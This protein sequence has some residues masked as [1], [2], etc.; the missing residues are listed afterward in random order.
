LNALNTE[1]GIS[2][3]AANSPRMRTGA[4]PDAT[5]IIGTINNCAG[6]ITPWGT[7]IT[8]EENINYYFS[9]TLPVGHPEEGNLKRYNFGLELFHWSKFD[10][11]FDVSIE[12]NEPNRFGWIVEIDPFDPSSKPIKRTALGR[13]KHEGGENIIASDGRLVVYMGDDQRGEYLYKFV[14]RDKVD[15]ENRM[16]NRN[17]LDY[18]NLY[19]AKLS[20]DGSLKWLLLDIENPLLA[21]EF[22][23]QADI[24]IQPRSA[25]DLL[26]ATRLDRPEDVV[27]NP[28][29]GKV[30]VMLTNNTKRTEDQVD[31]PNPRAQNSF[32]HIIEISETDQNHSSIS[33]HWDI[34]VLCGDPNNSNHGA[35]WN[36]NTT[37][38]GWF[39]SPDNG[40]IDPA[41]RLWVATDQ[42]EKV[43][44][45]GTNDGLWAL[46]TEGAGRGTGKMFF[47]APNGAELCG[48]IFS[49]NGESLFVSIQHPGDINTQ[50]FATRFDT[51]TTLWPDFND[52]TPPRPSLMAIR[53]KGGGSVG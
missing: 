47:R 25:A 9:G 36:D 32:G 1:F 50:P 7:Y 48:P 35:K 28:K 24:L 11:R 39:T 53:R 19:A 17:L 12:P 52:G 21:R 22:E 5:A 4:D 18:G 45:S 20:E 41:G 49:D 26:G 43:Q 13:F 38:N 6:G 51:A 40:V 15:V 14:S 33:G 16:A 42:G 10:K 31:A 34:V 3:P 2:G 46:E 44:M 8:C 37:E 30:F 27:P 23:S 29:T